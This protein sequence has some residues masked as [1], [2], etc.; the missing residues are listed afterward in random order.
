MQHKTCIHTKYIIQK[1]RFGSLGLLLQHFSAVCIWAISTC[2]KRDNPQ[3]CLTKGSFAGC[4]TRWRG[5]ESHLLLPY[6]PTRAGGG[7]CIGGGGGGF[8]VHP[9]I[10][11]QRQTVISRGSKRIKGSPQWHFSNS[12]HLPQSLSRFATFSSRFGDADPPP[13]FPLFPPPPLPP[14][15][16]PRRP[17]LATP[18]GEQIPVTLRRTRS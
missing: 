8:C 12:T 5:L 1:M 17:T 15:H 16:P 18:L 14:S 9:T 7:G 6:T 11:H 4:H 2:S 10:Q 3:A 13:P